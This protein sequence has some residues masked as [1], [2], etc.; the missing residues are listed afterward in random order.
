MIHP[1]QNKKQIIKRKK[2]IKSI[3]VFL[4][5]F[6]LLN[7]GFLNSSSSFFNNLGRP[8]WQMKRYFLNHIE[9]FDYFF[10]NKSLINE[11]N[12][13]IKE[14]NFYL[15]TLMINYDILE[16]E[17][18]ELKELLGRLPV[19]NNFVL[20]NIL[21]KPNQSP[22]DT[23]IVDI[24]MEQG[25]NQENKVYAY[26]TLPIGYISKAYEKNSLISLYSN[27]GQK[28]EGFINDTNISVELIGRGGGNFEMIIPMELI[29]ENK[30]A[31]YLP[32][33]KSEIIAIV[34]EIISSPSDPYKKVI[35][36]SPVNVQN[37]KWVQVKK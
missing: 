35:L 18:I 1:Y 6:I 14:E 5:F 37:L 31:I 13:K 19:N 15:K 28:T 20:G 16:K 10:K 11:E 9:S 29:I 22:Y 26:G 23:L 21:T 34:E 4:L 27:P 24:G 17:N 8:I 2:I 33:P 36:R 12:K 3:I 25:I 7:L 32:G 30:T